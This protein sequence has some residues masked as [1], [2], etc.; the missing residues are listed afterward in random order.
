MAIAIVVSVFLVCLM[1]EA[2][3]TKYLNYKRWEKEQ[4]FKK[5]SHV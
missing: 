1:I 5:D 3:W 4:E 2:V